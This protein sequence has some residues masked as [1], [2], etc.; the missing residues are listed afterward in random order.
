MHSIYIFFVHIEGLH[1]VFAGGLCSQKC[2]T[3]EIDGDLKKKDNYTG[4]IV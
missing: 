3:K 4:F 1:S 2:V